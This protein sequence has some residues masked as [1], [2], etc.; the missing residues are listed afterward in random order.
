MSLPPLLHGQARLL[1]SHNDA[2]SHCSRT[3]NAASPRINVS[4]SRQEEDLQMAILQLTRNV[5]LLCREELL[6]E[7]CLAHQDCS[8]LAT[9]AGKNEPFIKQ[10]HFLRILRLIRLLVR[11]AAAWVCDS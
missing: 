10:F 5:G 11:Q 2:P 4:D 9:L 6:N 7:L 8:P 1:L 3:A